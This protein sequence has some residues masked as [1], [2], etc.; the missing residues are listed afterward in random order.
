MAEVTGC[1]K[2][3]VS[4]MLEVGVQGEDACAEAKVRL[5]VKAM[6]RCWQL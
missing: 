3:P 5:T 2:E 1:I 6:L 4:Y